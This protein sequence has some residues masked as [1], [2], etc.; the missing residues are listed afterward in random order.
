MAIMSFRVPGSVIVQTE[1]CTRP[2][3]TLDLGYWECMMN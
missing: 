1:H 2:H 3:L